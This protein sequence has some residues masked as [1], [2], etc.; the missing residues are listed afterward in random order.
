MRLCSLNDCIQSDGKQLNHS[1]KVVAG[2][3]G[4]ISTRVA[5][6]DQA[7]GRVVECLQLVND[8]RDLRTCAEGV[9]KA[10]AEENYDE[11]AQHIH[12]FLTLD[13]GVFKIGDQVG[14]KGNYYISLYFYVVYLSLDP[15][16]SLKHSYEILRNAQS[17]LKVVIEQKFDES[18]ASGD[19]LQIQR[20]FKLFPM[21]NDHS[22][23]LQRFG[24]YLCGKIEQ[25]GTEYYKVMQAGGTDDKRKNVLY[26][27]TLTMLLEGMLI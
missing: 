21:I 7:K 9:Q 16:T 17:Q 18:L 3:A 6:L 11:A 13:S 23:G 4:N 15:G 22:T 2:L 8:L 25:F 26:A 10:I 1:L 19:D 12:R 27:D 20:Y 14:S 24:K 5:A